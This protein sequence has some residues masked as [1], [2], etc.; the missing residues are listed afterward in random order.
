[1][2]IKSI[3]WLLALAAV[4]AAVSPAQDK[5]G[6][7]EKKAVP[8]ASL[9]RM[10]LLQSKKRP[11]AEAKRDLFIPQSQS[12]PMGMPMGAMMDRRSP[13]PTAAEAAAMESQEASFTARYVGYIRGKKRIIALILYENQAMALEEGDMLGPIWKVVKITAEGIEIQGSDGALQKLPLE[14]ERK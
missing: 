9:I 7:A 12:A 3:R 5:A 6:P 14:G 11:G 10:D 13:L 4:A 8:A 1:M 2:K